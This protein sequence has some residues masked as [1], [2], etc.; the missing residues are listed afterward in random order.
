MPRHNYNLVQPYVMELC[1]KHGLSY[2]CKPFFTAI[3]DVSRA[4]KKSG[5]MWLEEYTKASVKND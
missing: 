3:L 2:Q 4:M 1:K 5:E